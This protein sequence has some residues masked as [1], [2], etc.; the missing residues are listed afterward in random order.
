[1]DKV[2]LTATVK[3]QN[4][5]KLNTGKVVYKL[6]G[7]S[8]KDKNG[9]VIRAKVSKGQATITF[10]P[11]KNYYNKVSNLTAVYTENNKYQRSQSK[12]AKLTLTQRNAKIKLQTTKI[13]A[14]Q[15]DTITI[16]TLSKDKRTESKYIAQI[17]L[18]NFCF[19]F[20]NTQRYNLKQIK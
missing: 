16:K 12:K 7:I 4:N 2:K 9:K 5:K 20:N 15:Y 3:N 8:I 17:F 14:T 19:K 18:F 1:M 13:K 11:N 10:T 6:N